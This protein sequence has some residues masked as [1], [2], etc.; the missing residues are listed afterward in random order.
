M[1]FLDDEQRRQIG[2]TFLMEELD[3]TTFYGGEEKRKIR[4]FK[5][6]EK[7]LLIDEFNNLEKIINSMKD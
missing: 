5:V 7:A 4:P 3:I 2:F 6:E 1:K